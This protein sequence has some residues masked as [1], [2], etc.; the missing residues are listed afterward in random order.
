MPSSLLISFAEETESCFRIFRKARINV[1]EK[2]LGPRIRFTSFFIISMP[3]TLMEGYSGMCVIN[4][5][6]FA[7]VLWRQHCVKQHLCCL[8]YTKA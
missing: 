5:V 6:Q 2:L 4:A 3:S 8:Q 7:T 1:V